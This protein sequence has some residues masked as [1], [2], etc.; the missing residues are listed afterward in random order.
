VRFDSAWLLFLFVAAGTKVGDKIFGLGFLKDFR[1]GWHG[2]TA[3]TDLR[4]YL[5][6][7]QAAAYAG[8]IG[9]FVT[10]DLADGVA[11]LTA[12]V[13]KDPCSAGTLLGGGCGVRRERRRECK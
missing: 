1:E 5:L 12:I 11:V 8:E 13:C 10:A 3:L 4:F 9:A 7:V 6:F 2:V